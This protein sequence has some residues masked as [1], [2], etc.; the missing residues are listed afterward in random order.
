[1]ASYKQVS[2]FGTADAICAEGVKSRSEF[3]AWSANNH[4][5]I[6]SILKDAKWDGNAS[7]L[8]RVIEDGKFPEK[9]YVP[10]T[11]F[12]WL[13]SMQAGKAV[14]LRKRQWA[15]AD[16]F[17]GFELIVESHDH[18]YTF[19]VP[20]VCCNFAL[21]TADWQ[22]IAV[23]IPT[24]DV[25]VAKVSAP[26]IDVPEARVSAPPVN[27][28][29]PESKSIR[30]FAQVFVGQERFSA[31]TGNVEGNANV[32]GGNQSAASDEQDSSVGYGVK[33]GLNFP[34]NADLGLYPN[35]GIVAR[36]SS[37]DSVS[38]NFD[39]EVRQKVL[40]NGFIGAGIGAWSF[41]DS[42]YK[43]TSAFIT[44][45][46]NLS[47]EINWFIETRRFDSN[48]VGIPENATFGGLQLAF[49]LP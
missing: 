46:S 45:G 11:S 39:L 36:D 25:P 17:V 47:R 1:M 24:I 7:D 5:K 33:L 9:K 42:E 13:A 22:G 40:K 4:D 6:R 12:Y 29:I 28:V 38:I 44:V 3:Q 27:T 48:R 14:A 41:D 19:V 23:A 43:A 49:G 10:G 21:M 34:I 2:H 26:P 16:A 20:K 35:F 8:L 32:S 15:G 30:P 18:I 31:N 37:N